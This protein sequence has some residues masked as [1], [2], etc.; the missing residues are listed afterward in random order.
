MLLTIYAF[1]GNEELKRSFLQS[2]LQCD[3][4]RSNIM[5]EIVNR[6]KGS[7]NDFRNLFPGEETP[8]ANSPSF[9]H[10]LKS[11]NS[12][13]T[14]PNISKVLSHHISGKNPYHVSCDPT[15]L[16]KITDELYHFTDDGSWCEILR[17]YNNLF[18]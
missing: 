9:L 3:V 14:P 17:Y 12:E 6:Y 13:F 10:Q 16:K 18:Q 15:Q 7:I 5:N 1:Y 4:A 2:I 8:K 11:F